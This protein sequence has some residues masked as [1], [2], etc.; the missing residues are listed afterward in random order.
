MPKVLA[1]ILEHACR[2]TDTSGGTIYV[3]DKVSETFRVEAAHNMLEEH[4][5]RVR[6]HPNR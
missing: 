5:A 4:L 1:T 2:M 6:A 3:Y